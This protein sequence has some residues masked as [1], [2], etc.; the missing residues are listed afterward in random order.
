MISKLVK[1]IMG[2]AWRAMYWLLA[3]CF[4]YTGY[5]YTYI[6]SISRLIL[7]SQYS[8]TLL[9]SAVSGS[10][11]AT[12]PAV[13]PTPTNKKKIAPAIAGYMVLCLLK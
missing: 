2:L 9:R 12:C 10:L 13:H 11:F 6:R 5:S 3:T 7:R 4:L 1:L 8:W